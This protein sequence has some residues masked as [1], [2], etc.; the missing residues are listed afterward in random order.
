MNSNDTDYLIVGAGA[1]GLAFADTI[2][3][4]SDDKTVTIVDRYHQPGGHWTVAYPF[5]RLHQPSA[6]YGV[7]SRALGNDFID[8]VGWNA[9]LYELA[10]GNE[11]L[12]YFDE[13]M[14]ETLLPSGRVNY[15]PMTEYL[16]D[17]LCRSLLTGEEFHIAAAKTVD[18]TYLDVRVPSTSRPAFSVAPGVT[19]VPLND[20]VKLSERPASFTVIGSGKTGIDACLWLLRN[21]V[22]P[23]AIR[24]V[25]PREAW[26][27][28]RELMQP[29]PLFAEKVTAM[30]NRQIE[31]ILASTSVDDCFDRLDA[32]NA[33]LRI[34]PTVKPSMYKCATVTQA[35]VEHLRQITDIIRLGHVQSIE[36][37]RIVMD[38][39]TVAVTPSTVY[40][41]C[42]ANGLARRP[43]A[44]V[45]DGS[46]I[47]LQ[48][49]RSCQQVFSA[50]LIAHIELAYTTDAEKNQLAVPVP[51]PDTDIDY[52]RGTL[53]DIAG[54]LRW[55]QDEVLSDWLSESRLN[56]YGRMGVPFPEEPEALAAAIQK[57]VQVMEAVAAKLE[58]LI[59]S[60]EARVTIP[61]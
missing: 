28:D 50:A 46:T 17:G 10:G 5:V 48:A 44:P 35:E 8:Q 47:I 1:M 12:A 57:Y 22:N 16:G 58:E 61:S 20:L 51:H 53:A 13:V 39:G 11:I 27:W 30:Q 32:C 3:G 25:T 2:I 55:G 7:N 36:P 21:G 42:T 18:S 49:V 41:D 15:L 59:A 52:L 26:L 38:A 60:A 6:A 9:G 14:H 33:L 34:D 31:A 56:L 29:G 40:I 37:E 19:C 4:E 43:A 54:D 24:W 23:N 45:F